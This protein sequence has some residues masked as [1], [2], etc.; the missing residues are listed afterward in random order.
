MKTLIVIAM[1]ALGCIAHAEQFEIPKNAECKLLSIKDGPI[2]SI[3]MTYTPKKKIEKEKKVFDLNFSDSIAKM[4]MS[5][6]MDFLK[7]ALS[8]KGFKI[9][10]AFGISGGKEYSEIHSMMRGENFYS[11]FDT[12][13]DRD[14][15]FTIILA[16]GKRLDELYAQWL[17]NEYKTGKEQEKAY[18][19]KLKGNNASQAKK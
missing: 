6:A 19:A 16:N 15:G 5:G 18:N 14:G 12:N 4:N 3:E 13:L 9:Q 11:R 10:Y 17:I 8:K 2:V 7:K 1:L